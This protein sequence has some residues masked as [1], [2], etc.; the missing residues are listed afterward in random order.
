MQF[1]CW[2]AI[3]LYPGRECVEKKKKMLELLLSMKRWKG[4]S[5]KQSRGICIL[6]IMVTWINTIDALKS[7]AFRM[8]KIAN[9]ESN[10]NFFLFIQRAV[11]HYLKPAKT[12]RQMPA[13]N[14]YPSKKSWKGGCAVAEN[15]RIEGRHFIEKTSQKRCRFCLSR[16]RTWCPVCNVGLCMQPCFRIF[17]TNTSVF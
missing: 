13:I 2:L 16:S 12:S 1:W 15:E 6:L 8:Y 14:I 9:P 3:I 5:L 10:I 7:A 4:L 11:I 17:H